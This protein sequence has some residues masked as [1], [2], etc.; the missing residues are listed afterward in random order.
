MHD[1][2]LPFGNQQYL[3]LPLFSCVC[4]ISGTSTIIGGDSKE[5]FLE[6]GVTVSSSMIFQTQQ[7]QPL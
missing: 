6:A 7:N 4:T 5:N 3:I 1:T 2:D